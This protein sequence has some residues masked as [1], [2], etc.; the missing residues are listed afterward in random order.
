M[1]KKKKII[2][3]VV[4]LSVVGV[5]FYMWK[6]SKQKQLIETGA[7]TPQSKISNPNCM[8]GKAS[9]GGGKGKLISVAGVFGSEGRKKVA[10]GKT[11][12]W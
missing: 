2:L 10:D 9:V 7:G 12:C 6:K 11:I 3:A 8:G 5:A 4:G 1:D